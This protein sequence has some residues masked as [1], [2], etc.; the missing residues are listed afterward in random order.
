MFSPY[1]V[2]RTNKK[3]EGNPMGKSTSGSETKKAWHCV[4][5]RVVG[6]FGP[7]LY[8]VG[9]EYISFFKE[10]AVLSDVDVSSDAV[11][12]WKKFLN[13][14]DNIDT[15]QFDLDIE[16]SKSLS[17]DNRVKH[18]NLDQLTPRIPNDDI[19]IGLDSVLKSGQ[20][21]EGT[22]W[23]NSPL[24]KGFSKKKAN[25]NVMMHLLSKKVLKIIK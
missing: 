11:N 23:S 2:K 19:V 7:L 24:S 8:E 14:S 5:S 3:R 4:G 9:I 22:N 1:S 6:G 17:T 10:A 21:I 15:Y 20:D 16:K 18:A 25:C 13:R 12:V